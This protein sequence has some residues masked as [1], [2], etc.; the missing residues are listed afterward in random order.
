M[1]VHVIRLGGNNIN[2]PEIIQSLLV[3]LKEIEQEH[4]LVISASEDIQQILVSG[5][6]L[7]CASSQTYSGLLNQLREE[8]QKVAQSNQLQ[9]L[10]VF[11]QNLLPL[12][13]LLQGIQYTGD[14][15]LA[16]RDQV[17]SYAEIITTA[18]L[19]DILNHHN[20]ETSLLYPQD[21]GLV[22]SAEYGNASILRSPSIENIRNRNWDR[23]TL[24]PG[25]FG[26][27][28]EG[29]IA[30]VGE[31]AADYTAAALASILEVDQLELWEISKSFKT[32][33]DEI[34][35]HSAYIENLT[36]AEASELAYF[37]HSSI[38]PRIVEPL[39]EQHIPIQVFELSEGKKILKTTINS[40]Q[41]QGS[42]NIKSVAH[43]DDIAILKLN[44]P[45]VG[46]KPG[47]LSIVTTAF[48][49]H[50]INIRSVITAQTSI[51]IIINKNDIAKAEKIRQQ[52]DLSSV[53][54]IEFVSNISLIAIV[55][56]GMQTNHGISAQLF[57]AVAKHAINV[58]LSGSGASDLV[59]YLIVDD[60]D[61][62][63]AIQEIHK[64]FFNI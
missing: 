36:Y 25:S 3:I 18:L 50:Q 59:S 30:R 47:I 5:L 27:T 2:Q 42:Q 12:E 39:I 19:Q 7:I 31:R 10:P 15:S 6:E 45:G 58:L 38:H 44:G 22:V 53:N 29:K 51:N 46:F 1:P 64:I 32:A 33:D 54:Q 26:R 24:I 49:Q 63:K 9:S 37:H 62:H 48:A 21:I 14:Y 61:K 34:I 57:S 60:A 43:S 17:L 11:E 55:G 8:A 35:P 41:K 23:I 28:S 4:L 56:H 16:L 40:T 52:L 13:R 20:Q